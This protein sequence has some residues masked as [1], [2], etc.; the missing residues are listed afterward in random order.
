MVRQEILLSDSE[1]PEVRL[2]ASCTRL[3]PIELRVIQTGGVTDNAHVWVSG[4]V[5]LKEK[6][7]IHQI[8]DCPNV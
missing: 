7:Y 1:N 4:F 8:N 5:F 2:E 3:L 6:I